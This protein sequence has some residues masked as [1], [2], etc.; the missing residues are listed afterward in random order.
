M[1]DMSVFLVTP[2]FAKKPSFGYRCKKS[3]EKLG[4]KV[5]TFNYRMY[6]LHRFSI[7]NNIINKTILKKALFINPDMMFVV[8]G[9][10]FGKGVIQKISDSGIKTVN[11]CLD[12]PFGDYSAYNKI[13][14]ITEYDDFLLFDSYYVEKIK[15]IGQENAHF[16][17]IG[18]DI[19]HHSEKI[20]FEKRKY[21]QYR[22]LT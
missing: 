10:K 21:E 6:Q 11:W 3:F 22:P 15:N 17:P 8:K 16:L 19:Q 4:Y 9:E 2:D 18:V 20:P 1:K 5:Y 7:S 14:N 12:D 13:N